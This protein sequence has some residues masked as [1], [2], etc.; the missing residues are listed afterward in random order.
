[1][2]I[3][4]DKAL[5]KLSSIVEEMATDFLICPLFSR[6]SLMTSPLTK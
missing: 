1:M 6:I 3:Y 5:M 4:F 2:Q